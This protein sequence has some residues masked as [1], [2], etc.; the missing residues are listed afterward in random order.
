MVVCHKIKKDDKGKE[1]RLPVH[2]L[3]KLNVKNQE[4]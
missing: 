1:Y 3:C 4:V 2:N